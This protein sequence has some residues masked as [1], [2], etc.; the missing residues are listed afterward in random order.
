MEVNSESYTHRSKG[1]LQIVQFDT[2]PNNVFSYVISCLK[3]L[4]INAYALI[5]V[6]NKC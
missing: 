2:W 4:N 5:F 1:L 3:T 6:I